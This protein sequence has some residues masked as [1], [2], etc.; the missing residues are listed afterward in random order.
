MPFVANGR[1]ADPERV[2]SRSDQSQIVYRWC[3]RGWAGTRCAVRCCSGRRRRRAPRPAASSAPRAPPPATCVRPKQKKKQQIFIIKKIKTN[4]NRW[5]RSRSRLWRQKKTTH[6]RCSYWS[7]LRAFFFFFVFWLLSSSF[8]LVLKM[9]TE[10][11]WRRHGCTR[12]PLFDFIREETRRR[13]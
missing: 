7:L 12:F 3:R 4:T 2:V 6:F 13:A 9:K 10:K 8:F 11:L 1:E 5:N